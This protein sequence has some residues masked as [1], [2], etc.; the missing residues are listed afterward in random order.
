MNSIKVYIT[1]FLHKSRQYLC[2]EWH[3]GIERFY[4]SIVLRSIICYLLS[5]L[6]IGFLLLFTHVDLI[7]SVI[8][9]DTNTD[10]GQL[11]LKK[12]A[13]FVSLVTNIGLLLFLVIDIIVALKK[14]LFIGMA[15]LIN[16]IGVL[17]CVIATMCAMGAVDPNLKPY[18]ALP[19]EMGVWICLAIFFISLIILKGKSLSYNRV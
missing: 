16:L 7:I 4:S 18:G 12:H 10:I 11:L 6:Y 2:K 14:C 13:H 5:I 1:S 19:C 3:I 9:D 8:N 17:A 15:T